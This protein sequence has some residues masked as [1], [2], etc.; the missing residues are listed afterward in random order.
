MDMYIPFPDMTP[1]TILS[2]AADTGPPIDS[3][4]RHWSAYDRQPSAGTS[5]RAAM[6]ETDVDDIYDRPE[7][8]GLRLRHALEGVV[9]DLSDQEDRV[10]RAEVRSSRVP[11]ASET[12][13]HVP[14][15]NL[16]KPT[17]HGRRDPHADRTH[18]NGPG[19]R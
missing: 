8:P 14:S 3:G 2:F 4:R 10:Y 16:D 17:C 9:E 1:S 12:K 18:A 19:S 5:S 13:S 6:T 7:D 11:E 15:N